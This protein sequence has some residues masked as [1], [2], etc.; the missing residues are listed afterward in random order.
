MV[1]LVHL[2]YGEYGATV[3]NAVSF[4][5]AG[6][7]SIA[8]LYVTIIKNMQKEGSLHIMS[9]LKTLLKFGVP[10]SIATTLV[11]VM[12]QYYSFLVAIYTPDEVMGNYQ[13]ALN[14]AMLVSIFA[15]SVATVLFPTF[16][17]VKG[18]ED[19][20][21]LSSVF[22]Y[23]VK[24]TSL[25]IVPAAFAVMALSEPGV[26]TIFQGRYEQ[27]PIFLSLYVSTFLYS[28]L[29]NLSAGA[30]INSQGQ[31]Q[32]NL[33]I[34]LLS[35]I[36]GVVMSL[37]LIPPFGVFG[38][39]VVHICCGIPGILISLWWIKKRYNATIDYVSSTKILVAS[40]FSGVLTYAITSQLNFASWILLIIGSA[41]FLASYMVVAPLIGAV[42]YADTQSLKDVV[43]SLGPLAAV[44]NPILVPL[45]RITARS[46]KE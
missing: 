32:F 22:Q 14:F 4:M 1:L 25:L 35:F 45:E 7:V 26:Q 43:N 16:S 37:L 28:A 10:I 11:G 2:Q 8:I 3:G 27:T 23:S 30:L 21:T 15:T 31:T 13:V 5:A 40:A 33:K 34:T 19:Q 20:K 17:K 9:T 39:L 6:L 12:A 46:K 24:Y 42:N 44:L 18:H 29:G 41:V 38:L 36:I